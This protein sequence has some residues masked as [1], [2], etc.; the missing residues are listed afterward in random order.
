MTGAVIAATMAANIGLSLFGSV[1][2][3]ETVLDPVDAY[4]GVTFNTNGTIQDYYGNSLGNWYNPTTAGIGAS[5]KVKFT[6]SSGT[7][8]STEASADGV[9]TADI[10]VSRSYTK[11]RTIV[12]SD[13]C[14]GTWTVA[15]LAESVSDTASGTVTA[16][17]DA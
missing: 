11:S 5:Y 14:T 7:A 10:S 17:V 12:G 16:T 13:T 15:N 3:I 2:D 8:F 6:R 1:N 4:A 9:Y